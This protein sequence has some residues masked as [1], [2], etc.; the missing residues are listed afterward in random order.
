MA[1][2]MRKQLLVAS[3]LAVSSVLASTCSEIET[4]TNIALEY[5]LALAYTVHQTEYW[6][7][8]CGD[9]KPSCIIEPTTSEEVSAIVQVL[10]SNNETFAIKS[11]GHNPN[12]NFASVSDGPLISTKSLNEVILDKTKGTVRVGPGNRWDDVSAALDGTGYTVIGGRIGN[13]GVGGYMLGG[14]IAHYPFWEP[15]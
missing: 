2:S 4:T 1:S 7:T 10:L 13:V 3:V 14:K 12:D 11:G 9:L 6:S 8:S 15:F 5:R